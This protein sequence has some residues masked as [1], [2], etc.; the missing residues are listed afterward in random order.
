MTRSSPPEIPFCAPLG[1]RKRIRK[2]EGEDAKKQAARVI[3]RLQRAGFSASVVFKV[4]RA[5]EIEVDEAAVDD[6]IAVEQT[7]D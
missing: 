7:E 2:P 1:F 4:L 3:G 6:E 5:W